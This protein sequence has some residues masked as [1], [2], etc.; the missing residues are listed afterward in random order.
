[1][2][3]KIRHAFFIF[4]SL[5]KTLLKIK[6]DIKFSTKQR[7]KV[8]ANPEPTHKALEPYTGNIA[9]FSRFVKQKAISA[10]AKISAILTE[11]A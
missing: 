5:R 9:Y 6:R 11:S 3:T 2:Q 1:M 4:S 7:F 10:N 8:K